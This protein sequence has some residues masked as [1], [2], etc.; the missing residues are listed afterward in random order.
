WRKL[1]SSILAPTADESPPNGAGTEQQRHGPDV[2]EL[3]PS[4]EAV[5]VLAQGALHL[6]QFAA[7]GQ[8]FSA[9]PLDGF[10][11]LVGEDDGLAFAHLLKPR[12]LILQLL[13]LVSQRLLL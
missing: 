10:P 12:E 8:H 11:L 4:I 7:H 5:D 13:E 1:F 6:A 3:E 9:E 2:G